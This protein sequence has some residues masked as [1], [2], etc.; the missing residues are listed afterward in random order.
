MHLKLGLAESWPRKCIKLPIRPICAN[1]QNEGKAQEGKKRKRKSAT[2]SP[3]FFLSLS[4][5]LLSPLAKAGKSPGSY[6]QLYPLRVGG[7]SVLYS[8]IEFPSRVL[9][10]QAPLSP[11]FLP[12][13]Y[14][15]ACQRISTSTRR[16][17]KLLLRSPVTCT[18]L[19]FPFFRKFANMAH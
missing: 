14:I 7:C 17:R 9:Q 5:S 10:G 15:A 12:A 11:Q 1:L 3:L 2:S 19:L 8:R 6:I 4:L 18:L 16:Y 13:C